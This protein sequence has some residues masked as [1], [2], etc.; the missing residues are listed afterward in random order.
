MNTDPD[1]RRSRAPKT[2]ISS[3]AQEALNLQHSWEKL[4]ATIAANFGMK[5]IVV[6]L[7][8]RDDCRPVRRTDAE[9]RLKRFI[10]LLR[11]QYVAAGEALRYIYVTESGHSS[12]NLH[13]HVICNAIGNDFRRIKDTWSDGDNVEFQR[14]YDKGYD[15]WARYLS[16]EPRDV[17]R[18]YVGERMWRSSKGL[19]K[20]KVVCGWVSSNSSLAIPSAAYS[21]DS[22]ERSNVYGHYKYVEFVLPSTKIEDLSIIIS[23]L[24]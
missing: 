11:K 9:K 13:H 16:K 17:G 15:G 2:T 5:D 23:D 4:K 1:V 10:R 14:I 24:G 7:T 21:I 18:H 3:V 20:P 19:A 6:T 8:Y 22:Q 12:G